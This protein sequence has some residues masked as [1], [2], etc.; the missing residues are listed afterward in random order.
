[1]AALLACCTPVLAQDADQG[2]GSGSAPGTT[3]P[4]PPT[5]VDADGP[6][7]VV[8]GFEL[9]YLREHPRHPSVEGL[10]DIVIELGVIGDGYVAPRP[11]VD[12]VRLRLGELNGNPNRVYYASALQRILERVRDGLA[13]AGLI[14]VFVA[15]DPAQ[16]NEFG[17]DLRSS[18]QAESEPLRLLMT[19]GFVSEVRTLASGDRVPTEDRLNHPLH[20]RI[21]DRS[22]IRPDGSGEEG[23]RE[24]LLLKPVLDDYMFLLSR[25]PGRRVDVTVAAGEDVG[26]VTLDYL[27]SENKP[28]VLYLQGSNT[29]TKQ[30]SRWRQRIGMVHSQLTNNDDILSLDYI[31]AEFDK[32]HAF[33]ASYDARVFDFDRLRWRIDGLYS[34]FR[35][36]DVGVVDADFRGRTWGLGAEVAYNFYQRRELFLDVFAGLR[37]ENISVDNRAA[38]IEGRESFL[39]PRIGV[40]MDRTGE[41][42]NSQGEMALE[43]QF[44]DLTGVDRADLNRLG[45]SDPDKDWVTLQWNLSHS[46]YLEPLLNRVAWED[47]TTPESST[48]AHEIALNFRGQHAF[49][50]RLIPQRQQVAGGF[51]TVRG[52]P[53][54][55]TA[56]DTVAILSAEYRFHVPRVFRVKPQPD[57]LFGESFRFAPQYVYGVPDWD[58]ILRGFVDI[59]RTVN[60]D[61]L[62]FETNETLIGAGVGA[63]LQLRRNLNVRLDWGF[64][65]EGLKG[66][67]VN[68][69][70]NRLHFVATILF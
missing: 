7:Y 41:W 43:F 18:T 51:Y 42:Y 30:T 48:L 70:S 14:G 13:G 32:A 44:G 27:I 31:T 37:F 33:V 64:A 40:R 47:P 8:R 10:L 12:V 57:E 20:Q 19:T 26:G 65:L 2:A 17:Q 6:S 58:L 53:E 69:G 61:R 56:G 45:R 28:F 25:H 29:G 3:Q 60:S 11:G 52:Y 15:P 4:P 50:N 34:E 9:S 46:F 22:P 38:D 67:D 68:S 24:E 36:S 5:V 66:P 55:V 63:E 54:S 16:I 1:M 59:G 21:I 39:F 35:A 49:G 62:S 23:E